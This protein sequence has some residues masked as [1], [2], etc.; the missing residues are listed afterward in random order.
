MYQN[1]IGLCANNRHH[2]S[3]KHELDWEDA[4]KHLRQN[5]C[6]LII[7]E[8]LSVIPI[9]FCISISILKLVKVV[10]VV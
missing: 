8:I 2:S 7:Y 6:Y 4:H 10:F 1:D 3:F 9:D 5:I